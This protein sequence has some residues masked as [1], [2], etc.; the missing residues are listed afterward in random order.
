DPPSASGKEPRPCMTSA[1]SSSP[2]CHAR[3]SRSRHSARAEGPPP[4]PAATSR[5]SGPQAPAVVGPP[6]FIPDTSHTAADS[7]GSSGRDDHRAGT[8]KAVNPASASTARAARKASFSEAASSGSRS[9]APARCRP[10]SRTIEDRAGQP[11][12]NRSP[13]SPGPRTGG[14]D[15]TGGTDRTGAGS[16]NR[17]EKGVPA[18]AGES[19]CGRVE[20]GERE[21]LA[22]RRP[23]PAG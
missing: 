5:S 4:A 11:P 6:P 16:E 1:T 21:E 12:P 23:A 2:E 22:P 19:A 15:G 10:N 18:S 3:I 7:F 8:V 9:K 17:P 20:A 13:R 14:A